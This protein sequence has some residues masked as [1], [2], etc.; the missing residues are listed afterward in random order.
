MPCI[1]L[2][3][4][5]VYCLLP[6]T[7]PRKFQEKVDLPEKITGSYIASSCKCAP[8]QYQILFC[9][10]IQIA[11]SCVHFALST[12]V[13]SKCRQR[14]QC[15]SVRQMLTAFVQVVCFFLVILLSCTKH[16]RCPMPQIWHRLSHILC[17]N[18]CQ[19]ILIWLKVSTSSFLPYLSLSNCSTY[20]LGIK[21]ETIKAWFLHIPERYIF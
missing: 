14:H 11:M 5:F 17:S 16:L 18:Y 10:E 13:I 3:L 4:R 12:W 15:R 8:K 6:N 21:H 9:W 7:I 19:R 20:N 2:I 1:G